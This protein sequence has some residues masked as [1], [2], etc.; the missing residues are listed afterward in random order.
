MKRILQPPISNENITNSIGPH[1][2]TTSMS[3]L[4]EEKRMEEKRRR[5]E[6]ARKLSINITQ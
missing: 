5:S 6:K 3:Y 1:N 4:M 2:I